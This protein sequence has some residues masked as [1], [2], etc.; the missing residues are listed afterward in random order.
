MKPNKSKG[1]E[2]TYEEMKRIGLEADIANAKEVDRAL[3]EE[4][5]NFSGA[6]D[7][8]KGEVPP[9]TK[10]EWE[11]REVIFND[12]IYVFVGAKESDWRDAII[13]KAKQEQLKQLRERV[14]GVK[15]AV[16]KTG[17]FKYDSCYDDVLEII[18]EH[19]E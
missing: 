13:Q 11:E 9:K 3:R 12:K 16:Q 18:D 8:V 6:S 10:E 1:E 15:E 19:L 7:C 5:E 2:S 14:V 17:T 4:I